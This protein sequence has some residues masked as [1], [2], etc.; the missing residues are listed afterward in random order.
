LAAIVETLT[1]PVFAKTLDGTIESWNAGAE[2]LYGYRADE[3]VGKP[4]GILVPPERES[5]IEPMLARLRADQRIEQFETVRRRKD[6]TDVHVSL[7]VSPFRRTDGEIVGALVVAHDISKLVRREEIQ[8]LLAEASRVL[9]LNSGPARTLSRVAQLTLSSL[10]D[11]CVVETDCLAGAPALLVVA[12]K[13]PD[14]A[15]LMREI[16]RLYP[17]DPER[18]NIPLRVLATGK[19][20]L[21]PEVSDALLKN[22]A[23]NARHLRMLRG[24]ALRS[25]IVAPL[26]VRGRTIGTIQLANAESRRRFTPEDLELAEDLARRVS[27]A[28]DNAA[29]RESE[30]QARR[31]AELAAERVGRLQAATAAFSGALTPAAVAQVLVREGAAAVGA[32]GAF[33]RLLTPDGRH[34][35]LVASLGISERY[36]R[37]YRKLP[38]TSPLLDA[39]VFRT[40]AERFFES[41]TV[42][43]EASPELAREHDATGHEAIAFVPL[44]LRRR[45]IGLIALSFV[46]PR[47]FDEDDRELLRTLAG[48]CAEALERARLYDAE[49]RARAAA[50][51]AIER[52]THLQ[53]LAAELAQ[54]LTPAQV[55]EVIVAQ[56]VASAG[57]DAGAL[58][59]LGDDGTMLEAVCAQGTD[60]DLIGDEWRRIPLDPKLPS[61]DAVRS[62]EPVFIESPRDMRQSYPLMPARQPAL[63]ARAGAHI[64]LIVGEQ[65]L[66]V[67]FL[68]FSSPRRFSES[69][70]SFVL[71]L[72]RQGAQALSRAQLYETALEARSRLSR[73]VERFQD[74]VVSFDR[75][76]RVVFANSTARRMLLPAS[77]EEGGVVPETW[78]GFPLRSFVADLF[79]AGKGAL[80][81][82]VVGEDGD[83][84]FDVTGIRA[85]R[86]EAALVVVSDV[87]DRERRRR[88]ER[89]FVANA[90]HELRT[91]LAAITSSVERLQAGARE[92][93]DKRDRYLGHIQHESARLNRLASSLLVLARAQS[94]E[95][96]PRS[97]EIALHAFLEDLAGEVEV[98]PGVELVLDCPPQLLVHSNRDLLEHAL[99]NLVGN[100]ARHTDRGRI[101]VKARIDPIGALTI[102]VSDTGSGIP[103][104]ELGRLFDRFYRGPGEAGRTGFGLGLPIVKEAVQAIGGRVEIESVVGAGTTARIMLPVTDT[105]VL[106]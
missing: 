93:P 5:E 65:L 25:L 87:S 2:Y 95:E 81:A 46:N 52:T 86:A 80:E 96:E 88:V 105:A 28:I 79:S 36:V 41:A 40:G 6:G 100:A 22:I 66:G 11:W 57:A 97:E 75:R 39:E 73:L 32:S 49:R 58:Q 85:V 37:S 91:P 27:L 76:G 35:K 12:H 8:R 1:D 94:Q 9:T 56:G 13:D 21:I 47:T 102:D 17:P 33:V 98:V 7:N 68:G 18:P 90:A 74:G 82:Q 10:T 63:R 101:C 14:K 20:E 77:L 34:L 53:S 78:L 61:T 84:V 103:S 26:R 71:A 104:E 48:Q 23:Q 72:G 67:L 42:V 54:A 106:A 19:A 30:Q 24:L 31:K 15:E 43:Q 70:R 99:L 29:L 50:E 4:V 59:L 92:I 55:A 45:P 44:R 89:E 64:P 83:Q 38:L 69:Q 16:R 62:R 3:V 51:L 60:P